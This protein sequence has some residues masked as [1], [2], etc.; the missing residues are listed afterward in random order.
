MKVKLIELTVISITICL[1]SFGTYQ[2]NIIWK[3]DLTLWQDVVKKSPYKSRS[4]VN[5]GIAYDRIG[6]PKKAIKEYQRAI[7]LNPYN[8]RAI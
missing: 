1:Y 4:Y 8:Y 3:D 5:L 6:F 7:R 2:R